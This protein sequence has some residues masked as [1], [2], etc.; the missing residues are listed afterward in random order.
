MLANKT[1]FLSFP[2]KYDINRQSNIITLF[3]S[4][5]S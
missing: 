5:I 2:T 1:A 4:F 3:E